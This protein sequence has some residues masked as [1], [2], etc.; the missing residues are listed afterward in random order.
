MGTDT[1]NT[2]LSAL[3]VDSRV[4]VTKLGT[5]RHEYK[6]DIISNKGALSV[7]HKYKT[8]QNLAT[9]LTIQ[10][11]HDG[12]KVIPSAFDLP[13]QPSYD[14][15]PVEI[16]TINHFL[17]AAVDTELEWGIRIDANT[18]VYKP[19]RLKSSP[20]N[21]PPSSFSF[22][23]RKSSYISS[24]KDELT[25]EEIVLVSA[26]IVDNRI[27]A[28]EVPDT[29]QVVE[30]VQY[31]IAIETTT[32]GQFF[33]WRRYMTFLSLAASLKMQCPAMA[34]QF[35]LPPSPL[36]QHQLVYTSILQRIEILNR[37]LELATTTKQL[38]WGIRADPD[39]CLYKRRQLLPR[40]NS[41]GIVLY[42]APKK[43]HPVENVSLISA[44]I[45][46]YRVSSR[47]DDKGHGTIKYNLQMDC[48]SNVG[49]I[50]TYSIWRRFGTFLDLEKSL[51]SICPNIPS[52]RSSEDERHDK[53][54]IQRRVDSLNDFFQAI[55]NTDELE[56]G[57]RVDKDTT[58]FKQRVL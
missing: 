47:T 29:N 21:S 6:L 16:S 3:V 17:A 46:G 58:V 50:C 42:E 27:I 45:A 5:H 23:D 38:E 48:L 39:T 2:L 12:V 24:T 51:G 8:F 19:K 9:T 40:K 18:V 28:A 26:T 32:R 34:S 7:W 55:S 35:D 14:Q 31:C 53:A 49:G 33:L 37:F 1:I 43:E 22:V 36:K 57:I 41:P 25:H 56:W 44:K 54:L 20:S 11:L 13:R 10:L 52:L 30:C 4:L 15:P